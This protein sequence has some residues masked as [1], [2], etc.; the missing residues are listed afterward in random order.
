MAS[1]NKIGLADVV[2]SLM[3]TNPIEM[4]QRASELMR[5]LED[6]ATTIRR[7]GRV[8]VIPEGM[9]YDAAISHIKKLK[10]AEESTVNLDEHI[11]AYPLDAAHALMLVISESF[12]FDASFTSSFDTPYGK[13]DYRPE[14][15]TVHLSANP[16]DS[17]QVPFGAFSLPGIEGHF[18]IHACR[19]SK[20]QHSLHMSASIKGKYRDVFTKLVNDVREKL[21]TNS[22]YKGKALK[23]EFELEKFDMMMGHQPGGQPE[24]PEFMELHFDE[25]PMFNQDI[26]S[27]IETSILTPIKHTARLKDNGM[28]IKRTVMLAGKYGTGKTLTAKSIANICQQHG[29]T[30]LYSKETENLGELLNLAEQYA[31]ALVFVEDTDA[32]LGGERNDELNG[33]S[34]ELD[35]IDTKERDVMLVMTTNA[36]EKVAKLMLRPGRIDDV[37]EVSEPN[38]DTSYRLLCQCAKGMMLGSEADFR[39]AIAPMAGNNPAFLTEVV[40]KAKLRAIGRTVNPSEAGVSL[41]PEDIAYAVTAVQ[42]HIKLMTQPQQATHIDV[43]MS[44]LQVRLNDRAGNGQSLEP[45]ITH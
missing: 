44:S 42:T 9:T 13:V 41:V 22:I 11:V 12:G 25:V 35:G 1:E 21:K 8:V 39:K 3:V 18:N 37:I 43:P 23:I 6:R 24:A 32:I 31:P 5:E 45:S 14:F 4:A 20:G 36:I 17:V 30:F 34:L 29:W 15:V 7:E 38:A 2:R 27:Q 33:L 28:K 16:H 10:D 19:N 40:K 26:E